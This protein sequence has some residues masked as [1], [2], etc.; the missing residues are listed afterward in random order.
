MAMAPLSAA[1]VEDALTFVL[2]GKGPYFQ[3]V[4][5]AGKPRVV[6]PRRYPLPTKID[7]SA[8]VV[9]RLADHATTEAA[10][11]LQHQDRLLMHIDKFV[12][13]RQSRETS[14]HD[15]YLRREVAW[16]HKRSIAS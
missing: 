15:Y 3:P 1:H 12:C 2:P 6:L 16:R 9:D 7:A 8:A 10:A 13:R 11:G 4:G 14:A 5:Q